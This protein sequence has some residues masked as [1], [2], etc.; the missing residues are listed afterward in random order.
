MLTELSNAMAD[1]VAGAGPSVV[2]VQGHRRPASGVVYQDNTVLTTTRALGREDGLRVRRPDGDE[3][4]A[5]LIGWDPAS[6]LALLGVNGLGLRALMPASESPRVGHLALA[7]ARSWSNALTASAGIVSVIGGPLRTGRRRSIA[8]VLRTTA[9]MHEGFAGGAFVDVEGR[10]VG[11][12]TASEIRGLGVV[13]PAS[14]A[15][16]TA[17]AV[18]EHGR[19]K[20]G[21]LGIAGQPV[22]L[23]EG[24][25]QD[26]E[27]QTALLV[28]AV[29]AGSPAASA[30]VL[31]GDVMLAFDGKPVES[32]ED[33]LDLLVG[34][35]VGRNV[36]LRI[37]RGR[38]SVDLNVT[39][40][41]RPDQS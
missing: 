3:V 12:T 7:L 17:A 21:Y 23:P 18:L 20:R 9:P 27:H 30:G 6:S 4:D 5:E 13:I 33:L 11:I 19:L 16:K 24:Q 40:G 39:V 32:P 28:V 15:L 36:P 37:L 1:A 25:R 34:D 8:E 35:R 14:I 10:L 31:V 41:E 22:T 38:D 2:Q 26:D 29:T